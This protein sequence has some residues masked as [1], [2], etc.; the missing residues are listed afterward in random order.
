MTDLED[1]QGNTEF[2]LHA[3]SA[4]GSWQSVVYGFGGLSIDENGALNLNPWIPEKWEKLSFKIYWKGARI[5][6]SI[7]QDKIILESTHDLTIKVFSQEC[8]LKGFSPFVF[9]T[10]NTI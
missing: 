4:G 1:N 3:A 6:I 2:G 10:S 7:F 5:T 9:D 8:S